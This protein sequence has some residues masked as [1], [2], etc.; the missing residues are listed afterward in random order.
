MARFDN[1]VF[2]LSGG[3]RGLGEAQ[4]RQLVAEG[5]RVVIADVLVGPAWCC[6][7]SRTR[8]AA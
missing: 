1:Q 4:A 7:C 5:A 2:L 6:S 8:A 3:A